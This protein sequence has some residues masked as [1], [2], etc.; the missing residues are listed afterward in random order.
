M[1]MGAGTERE[2][3]DFLDRI[4]I[5]PANDV[6]IVADG[7]KRRFRIA[8]DKARE[9]NGE[10]CLYG[11]EH[12]A[13]WAKSYS[14]K[15]G[16]EFEKWF[17]GK[18][19]PADFNEEYF[20]RRE[21]LAV[22]RAAE[23]QRKMESSAK[24]ASRL[25]EAMTPVKPDHQYLKRKG[26]GT[27]FLPDGIGQ[28]GSDIVVPLRDVS[29]Q[30][31]NRQAISPSGEKRFLPG[32]KMGCFFEIQG[33]ERLVYFVEGL[34]TGLSV[35]EATGCHVVVCFDCGN[36]RPVCEALLSRFAGR[37]VIAADND[38]KTPGNPGVKC[39]SILSEEL[40]IPY[41]FPPFSDDEQGSDW[42]DFAALR[43]IEATAAEIG[44]QVDEWTSD[45]TRRSS[46]VAWADVVKNRPL[47]TIANVRVLLRHLGWKVRYDEV[48]KNA[49]YDIP[50]AYSLDNRDNAWMARV[51]S[52]CYKAGFPIGKDLLNL[53][54]F[55]IQDDFKCNP[56][57]EWIL[58]KPWDG[59]DRFRDLADSLVLT[60]RFDPAFRDLLL[61]RWLTS[62]VAAVF[63]GDGDL[64]QFRGVLVLKGPQ[65]IGKTKWLQALVPDGSG[66][67]LSGHTLDTRDKDNV[68]KCISHWIV[69]LGELDATFKASDVSR[70]K[71]FITQESDTIRLPYAPKP[72]KFMRRTV[73]CGSVNPD[74]FLVDSTGNSRWWSV[75]V[76]ECRFAHGLDMQQVWAQVHRWY[77]AGERHWL[78]RAEQERL[79][80][81][82]EASEKMD[83]V[84]DLLG[85]LYDWDEYEEN[86]KDG[87]VEYL[88]TT[89]ILQKCRGMDRPTKQQIDV[90]AATLRKLTGSNPVRRGKSGSRCYLVPRLTRNERRGIYG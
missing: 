81:L 35:H 13:G 43:G 14:A 9:R 69:E 11:D 84:E 48:K 90:A 12:P 41:V 57:R 70:L 68:A 75:P 1:I 8:G 39:A 20:R 79:N 5:P 50:G 33:G 17:A 65:A 38:R 52:E 49:W 62:C 72:S 63:A 83:P 7:T 58:S 21:R 74:H 53:Y 3:I 16:V 45:L 2:F 29:G 30:V 78:D 64:L 26:I 88:T 18:E 44:R 28:I 85:R 24:N 87:L 4:G 67:F 23:I 86:V 80:E 15:H 42:N 61:M 77:E 59:K 31:W 56:V 25:L 55:E 10:Y 76:S 60:D 34:A 40:D 6:D 71:S 36:L 82:N 73:F 51:L 89:E 66:W 32:R 19:A 37:M 22:E 46:A 54:L 27:G 47:R